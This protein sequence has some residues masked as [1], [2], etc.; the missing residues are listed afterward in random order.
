MIRHLHREQFVA[1]DPARIWDFF[2][3]PGNLD[4]LTPPQLR[5]RIVGDP[6]A[7]MY[8]G[9]MIE[10]RVGILPGVWTRWL[11]EITHVRA[12][13]Y[14]VDEQRIGPY[15]LWHHEHRFAPVVGGLQM[16]DHVTYDV[17][18][19]PAGALAERLWVRGQL[20]RIFD[21]RHDRIAALF[22]T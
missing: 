17:G 3:A 11:T 7:R 19:G 4:T 10:Y 8:A 12:G 18:W 20:R 15:R 22:P 16:T 13:E 6:P 1:G 5:F 9:Q 2:C 14:F 21:Y